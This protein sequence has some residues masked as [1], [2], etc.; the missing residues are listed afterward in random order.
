L[1]EVNG[2]KHFCAKCDLFFMIMNTYMK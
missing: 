1:K 2:K